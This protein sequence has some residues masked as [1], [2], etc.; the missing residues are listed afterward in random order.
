MITTIKYKDYFSDTLI[1]EQEA[2]QARKYKKVIE[3]NNLVKR[4]DKYDGGILDWVIYFKDPEENDE[5]ILKQIRPLRPH[6]ERYSINTV[7]SYG[8][9]KVVYENRYTND[10]NDM[11]IESRELIGREG[12]V[13]CSESITYGQLFPDESFVY[14]K[15]YSEKIYNMECGGIEEGFED[16]RFLVFNAEYY[17]DGILKYIFF[18]PHSTYDEEWYSTKDYDELVRICKLT[19]E[20]ARYYMTADF[21]PK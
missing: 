7:E 18:N 3:I 9:Y 20:Q 16:P 14:K 13:I 12:H 5:Q 4:I 15:F 17:P 8:A 11:T 1:T 2:L 10:D 21:F 6:S 19:L